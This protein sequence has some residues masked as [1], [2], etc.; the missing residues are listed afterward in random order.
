MLQDF[1]RFWQA[2]PPP[3]ADLDLI[4]YVIK[5]MLMKNW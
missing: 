1:G 2:S 5:Q 3:K 4:G